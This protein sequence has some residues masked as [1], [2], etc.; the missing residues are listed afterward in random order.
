MKNPRDLI[1]TEFNFQF[2][3][4]GKDPSVQYSVLDK[5]NYMVMRTTGNHTID[6]FH[7]EYKQGEGPCNAESIDSRPIKLSFEPGEDDHVLSEYYKSWKK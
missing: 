3:P 5:T 2:I 4:C 7:E 6:V 1:T